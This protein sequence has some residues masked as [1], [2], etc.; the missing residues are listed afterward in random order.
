MDISVSKKPDPLP[1]I[2]G[3]LGDKVAVE[4]GLSSDIAVALAILGVDQVLAAIEAELGI[5][6]EL[7]ATRG[8]GTITDRVQASLM[9]ETV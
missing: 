3:M 5:S 6:P 1:L 2:V 8:A 4:A 7:V 9:G